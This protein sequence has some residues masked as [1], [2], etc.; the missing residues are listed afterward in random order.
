MKSLW[1][2]SR[3]KTF[4]RFVEEDKGSTSYRIVVSEIMH[5]SE[6]IPFDNFYGSSHDDFLKSSV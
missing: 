5:T 4:K 3:K 2:D 6:V 1:N